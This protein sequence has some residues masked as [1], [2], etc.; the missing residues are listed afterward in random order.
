MKSVDE[1][2]DDGKP[3]FA[4][5]SFQAVHSP[6]AVPDDW[7]DAYRGQYDKGYDALRA[8]RVAA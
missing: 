5:L 7:L 2:K 3:F 6:F 4:Y 8:S 1:H